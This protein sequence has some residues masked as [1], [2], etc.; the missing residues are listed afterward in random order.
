M[1]TPEDDE[2]AVVDALLERLRARVDGLTEEV[3]QW[4]RANRMM[5]GAL[6]RTDVDDERAFKRELFMRIFAR[7]P[8]LE[9][10]AC[11]RL[12]QTAWRAKPEDC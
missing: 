7:R 9:V 3:E 10:E 8:T 12:V 1:S 2:K 4:Q 11:W 5:T 6:E